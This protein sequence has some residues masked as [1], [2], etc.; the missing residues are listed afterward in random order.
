M[1]KRK[2]P[3]RGK[4]GQFKKGGTRRTRRAKRRNPGQGQPAILVNPSGGA[5]KPRKAKRRPWN[6]GKKL[7]HRKKVGGYKRKPTVQPHVRRVNPRRRRRGKRNPGAGAVVATV[8]GVGVG[9]TLGIVGSSLFERKAGSL[10]PT[11]VSVIEL[12]AAL[13]GGVAL[14]ML[15]VPGAIPAGIAFGTAMTVPVGVRTVTKLLPAPAPAAGGTPGS[16]S[17]LQFA[18]KPTSI[19]KLTGGN[20]GAV[21]L[22]LGSASYDEGMGAVVMGEDLNAVHEISRDRAEDEDEDDD[23]E[24]DED[25]DED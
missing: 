12:G 5:S 14:A 4:G 11:M 10:S 15:P 2:T 21:E 19:L 9:G 7:T 1:R 3:A 8:L 24:N 20:M 22:A 16:A 13:V 6:K 18:P 17:G 23:E 25:D